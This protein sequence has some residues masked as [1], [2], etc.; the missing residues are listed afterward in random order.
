ME[1]EPT[2]AVILGLFV[3]TTQVS[4]T[5][6]FK[7]CLHVNNR[8]PAAY[9]ITCCLTLPPPPVSSHKPNSSRSC[10]PDLNFKADLNPTPSP[11]PHP[12]TTLIS[13]TAEK[14]TAQSRAAELEI[15]LARAN[16]EHRRLAQTSHEAKVVTARRLSAAEARALA[17]EARVEIAARRL[18]ASEHRLREAEDVAAAALR[19]AATGAGGYIGKTEG[20]RFCERRAGYAESSSEL[21]G[22]ATG[23][24]VT[25]EAE[26][27]GVL[28]QAAGGRAEDVERLNDDA[29]NGSAWSAEEVTRTPGCSA[30]VG[31]GTAVGSSA[32]QEGFV[33]ISKGV[34]TSTAEKPL[35]S[36]K[37]GLSMAVGRGRRT[38]VEKEHALGHG[39]G[40]GAVVMTRHPAGDIW[41]ERRSGHNRARVFSGEHVDY[42]DRGGERR[43]EDGDELPVALEW[44]S[45]A[46]T[47]TQESLLLNRRTAE[48]Q[49]PAG[50]YV[51]PIEES[52]QEEWCHQHNSVGKAHRILNK[53]VTTEGGARQGKN[54]EARISI[55][56]QAAPVP[57]VA[58]AAAAAVAAAATAAAAEQRRAITDAE[59]EAAA[60]RIDLDRARV[61]AADSAAEVVKSRERAT[62]N[63]ERLS[64]ELQN[65][66]NEVTRLHAALAVAKKEHSVSRHRVES[67]L[68]FLASAFEEEVAGGSKVREVEGWLLDARK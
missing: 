3:Q 8:T 2:A 26:T 27:R 15:K 12:Q 63:A 34:A 22:A 60:L 43:R 30:R 56:V 10:Y 66:Q 4:C 5:I 57:A 67:K 49:T 58:T 31:V 53:D 36:S 18:T 1:E 55:G 48:H 14:E 23:A 13:L 45:T 52:D 62:Q 50:E 19:G 21:V 35:V 11:P 65:T 6:L 33:E 16:G 59:R 20:V 51:Q 17:A 32:T 25:G 42:L 44:E 29:G 28:V 9:F 39:G 64:H 68:E 37:T 46:G 24:S 7:R 61:D 40:K 41:I 54:K 47:K 38:A